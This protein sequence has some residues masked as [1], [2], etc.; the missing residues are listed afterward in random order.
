MHPPLALA[1][2]GG[3]CARDHP[4]APPAPSTNHRP[5]DSIYLSDRAGLGWAGLGWAGLGWAGLGWA[6]LGWAGL[7]WAVRLTGNRR[8]RPGLRDLHRLHRPLGRPDRAD[9]GRGQR[10]HG[11]PAQGRLLLPLVRSKALP[12]CCASTVFLSKPASFLA[13]PQQQ[14]VD[15]PRRLDRRVRDGQ[16][17]QVRPLAIAGS[18]S[19]SL[20]LSLFVPGR[21][22]C[23]VACNTPTLL[24]P[25]AQGQLLRAGPRHGGSRSLHPLPPSGAVQGSISGHPAPITANL[26]AVPC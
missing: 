2:A 19:L 12:F 6:G 18:L 4:Q 26:K 3:P 22:C 16:S 1:V 21:A 23:W 15:L 10:R 7:G 20:S 17:N 9:A 13:V 8:A 25:G 14:A 24:P 11:R 5:N